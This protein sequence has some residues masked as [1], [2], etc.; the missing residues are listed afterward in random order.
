M[1]ACRLDHARLHHLLLAPAGILSRSMNWRP[2][3][4][5]ACDAN[6]SPEPLALSQKQQQE[7]DLLFTSLLVKAGAARTLNYHAFE[8]LAVPALA[9]AAAPPA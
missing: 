1:P 7:I 9:E 5:L 2:Y 4:A 6:S 8:A 3:A